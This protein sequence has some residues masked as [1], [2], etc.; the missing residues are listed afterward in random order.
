VIHY[1][2]KNIQLYLSNEFPRA[3]YWFAI[4]PKT[5]ADLDKLGVALNKLAE[6]DPTFR[7]KT[8]EDSRSNNHQWN[9]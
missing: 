4:E 9:G 5:Q 7:V 2:M 8:D 3:G 1:V 6:E